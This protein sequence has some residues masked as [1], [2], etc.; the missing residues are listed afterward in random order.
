MA[1]ETAT[2]TAARSTFDELTTMEATDANRIRE[3]I[4]AGHI[5]A[6]N[7]VVTIRAASSPTKKDETW[8]YIAYEAQDA[9]GMAALCNGKLEPAKPK[10]EEGEDTRTDADKAGGACDFFNY[11]RDLGVKLLVRN[12]LASAIAGPE[13]AIEAAAK[14]MLAAELFATMDEA[15][16]AVIAQR[17]A[18]GLAV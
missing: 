18:K 1:T 8:P 15:K 11:G 13:K 3:A 14:A 12:K 10:P 16:A 17:K 2:A 7:K 4:K 9:Q 6:V 5:K